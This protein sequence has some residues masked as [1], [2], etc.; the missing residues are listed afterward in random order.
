ML[1]TCWS[2]FTLWNSQCLPGCTAV[3][4]GSEV[5]QNEPHNSLSSLQEDLIELHPNFVRFVFHVNRW[6]Q[7][8]FNGRW[9][10]GWYKNTWDDK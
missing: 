5:C 10:P 2:R 1:K 7:S 8:Q 6:I 3:S 9:L 4:S